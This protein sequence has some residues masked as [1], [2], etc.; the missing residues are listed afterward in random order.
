MSRRIAAEHT[1]Q[2]VLVNFISDF[3]VV[4]QVFPTAAVSVITPVNMAAVYESM[5]CAFICGERV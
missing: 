2:P 5:A 3:F 4:S 1:I